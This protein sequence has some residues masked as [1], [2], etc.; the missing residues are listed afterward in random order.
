MKRA[1][2]W[3]SLSLIGFAI[4]AGAQNPAAL[5]M[6]APKLTGSAWL[7]VPKGQTV[8]LEGRRGKV[9]VVH[10]WTFG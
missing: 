5:A 10:F 6:A 2:L 9:T 8:S 3:V 7:N 4:P 1:A